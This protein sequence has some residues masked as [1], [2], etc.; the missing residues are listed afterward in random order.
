MGL[1][2]LSTGINAVGQANAGAAANE[3]AKKNAHL[4]DVAAVDAE[5]RGSKQAGEAR[6]KGTDIVGEQRLA[7]A[8][9][10]VEVGVGTSAQLA[11]DTR[12]A[13]ELDAQTIK[14]NAAREA[15]GFRTQGTDFRTQGAQAEARGNYGA[16]ASLLEGGSNT[17]NLAAKFYK[18]LK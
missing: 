1:S 9:S 10:G 13:A 12:A 17:A 5:Q 8:A 7:T 3:V 2:A 14:A 15:W 16:V 18:S 6:M 11:E 4:S